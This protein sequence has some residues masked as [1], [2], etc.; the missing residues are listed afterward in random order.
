M[1]SSFQNKTKQNKQKQK[2][3]NKKQKNK[4]KQR[5]EEEEE[6]EEERNKWNHGKYYEK[7]WNARMSFMHAEGAI[8]VLGLA[9]WESNLKVMRISVILSAPLIKGVKLTLF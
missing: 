7:K 9:M 3:K 2:T 4:R 5:K 6:E 8:G 1:A